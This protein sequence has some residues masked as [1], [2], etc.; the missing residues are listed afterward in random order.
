[1]KII[2]TAIIKVTGKFLRG[3]TLIEVLI[4]LSV[5]G[6]LFGIGYA[7]YRDFSRRQEISGIAKSI[8]GNLRKAQQNALSGVKPDVLV[9]KSQT[10]VGYDFY[11]VS[12]SEYQIRANCTGGYAVVLDVNLP[13]SEMISMEDNPILFNVLGNGTNITGSTVITVT[14]TATGQTVQITVGSGGDIQ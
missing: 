9:C 2:N 13:A 8:E 12:G 14:Q 3:Y 4:V 1:M 11:M 10:L 5:M 6:V 7:G